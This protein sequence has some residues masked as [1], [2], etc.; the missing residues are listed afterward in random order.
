M[1]TSKNPDVGIVLG[2]DSDFST[3]EGGLK[4]LDEFG[5]KYEVRVLSAHR[6]PELLAEY[7]RSASKR[8]I[9]VIIAAAGMSAALPGVIA[10]QTLLPV[11]GVPVA[12]GSLG[13]FDAL[14]AISQMPAG[15]PVA[16]V[17]IGA[18]GAKNAVL[19]AIRILAINDK[20]L[21]G[22]LLLF[23]EKLRK[24]VVERDAKLSLRNSRKRK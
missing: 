5:L 17:T 6:T 8:G 23:A 10:S 24:D 11:I 13:G 15:V 22:K 20:S 16:T 12:G 4:L 9:K 3:V 21:S 1:E 19:L 14:L 2:S 7:C 18:A